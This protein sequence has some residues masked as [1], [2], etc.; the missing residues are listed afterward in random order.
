[1]LMMLNELNLTLSVKSKLSTHI[2]QNLNGFISN[3]F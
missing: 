3:P 2:I 1:M